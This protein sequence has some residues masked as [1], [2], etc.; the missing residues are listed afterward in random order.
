MLGRT[1]A[2]VYSF[3]GNGKSRKQRLDLLHDSAL[4]G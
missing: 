4:L 2:V 1:S 3:T